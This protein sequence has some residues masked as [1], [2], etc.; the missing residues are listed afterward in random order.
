MS[1]EAESQ[2]AGRLS[3]LASRIASIPPMP[4]RLNPLQVETS[5][6]PAATPPALLG[7]D[8]KG[9]MWWTITIALAPLIC[10]I[11][12]TAVIGARPISS[13]SLFHVG[14]SVFGLTLAALVRILTHG[15]GANYLPILFV[16]ALLEVIL[17]LYSGG[18]FSQHAVQPARIESD[19]TFV[20]RAPHTGSQTSVSTARLAQVREDLGAVQDSDPKSTTGGYVLLAAF[21]IFSLIMLI[22]YWNGPTAPERLE[23]D[24]EARRGV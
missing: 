17:A 3:S 1:H 7:V 20:E 10:D 16:I 18:T 23:A 22:R 6:G 11:A 14:L 4:G 5:G 12:I 9:A 24:R 13:I 21:G 2:S 19:V 8:G 15:R